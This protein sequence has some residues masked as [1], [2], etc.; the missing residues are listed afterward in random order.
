MWTTKELRI[1]ETEKSSPSEIPAAFR[2]SE[3]QASRRFHQTLAGYEET[4]LVALPALAERLGVRA[5][6]AKDESKRFSL[7]AFKGLGGSY[8]MFRI[9]CELLALDPAETSAATLMKPENREK[10]RSVEFVTCTDGNHGR[11]VSWAAGL[12]GCR[13]HVYMP[14]GTREVRAEAIRQV[15]PAEVSI[16]DLSYDDTVL[17]A[18]AMSERH[19]WI[20]IQ[21]TSWDGYEKIPTWIVQGYLTMADEII[22]Q[23]EALAVRPTHVFLQAGVGAMA[24]GVLGCLADH[25]GARKPVAAIVEPESANCVFVSAH[26]GDGRPHSVE[27]IAHTMMAGLN[28]GTPC[29]L[30]WP[31]L[32]DHAEFFISCEDSV[33]ALGMQAFA[34]GRDGDPV[35]ISGESGA[36]GLGAAVQILTDD[37]LAAAREAMK[38]DPDAV[39]LFINTEGDTD[40]DNYRRCTANKADHPE[41]A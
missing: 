9:L 41:S 7:N 19:G 33:A 17:Y 2:A 16:T 39:L 24:G 15:G 12:F 27:G 21:D 5:V 18:K 37:S 35:V 28:C 13:A 14:C 34:A 10:L 23:L 6:Y 22:G 31:I 38:L 8:A 40:P 25:Y 3:A 20:L 1:L 26:A 36:A 30:T 29:G 32:R 4:P 11:G